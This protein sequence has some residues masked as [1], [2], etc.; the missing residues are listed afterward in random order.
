MRYSQHPPKN[1][2]RDFLLLLSRIIACMKPFP[3]PEKNT[4]VAGQWIKNP[5]GLQ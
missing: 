2:F 1:Q 3:G 5:G 4:A